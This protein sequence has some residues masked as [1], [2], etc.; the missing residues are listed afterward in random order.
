[1]IVLPAAVT[2]VSPVVFP[3]AS[4]PYSGDY[5]YI[6]EPGRYTLEHSV[7]HQYQAGVIIAAPSVVLDGQG[8][9][10]QPAVSG[11]VQSVGIWISLT[12]RLGRPVTGVTIRNV[13]IE[14]EGYGIYAE[15]AD[16]SEFVWGSDRTRDR[17]AV[18]AVSSPRSLTL[19][20]IRISSCTDGIVLRNQSGATISDVMVSGNTGS[21]IRFSGNQGI[22]SGSQVTGNSYD[23]VHIQ[24]GSDVEISGCTIDKNGKNGIRL[25]QAEGIRIF[26]N[27]LNNTHNID[28]GPE[29]R[30]IILATNRQG[31]E[32]IIGGRI[33]GGNYWADGDGSLPV[34]AGISDADGDGIGDSPYDPGINSS[35]PLPLF[36]PGSVSPVANRTLEP[37]LT[38]NPI[39]PSTPQVITPVPVLTPLSVISGIH[40][41]IIS[42][43]IP[44]E[45]GAGK[46]YPVSLSL[47]N[48][49]SADWIAQHQVGIK[50][51]EDA[52]LYGPEWMVVPISDPVQSG[53]T[54]RM[55]F[56]IKAPSKSGSYPLK[57][58]A[59]R[60]GSGIEV[61]YGRAYSKT[62]TVS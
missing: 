1:M 47:Y 26:N 28:A 10:I 34:Q 2:S 48:D 32:N 11:A 9:S 8:Y 53:Q 5:I 18:A 3:P 6:T 57:Y 20:E 27:I 59:A 19:S 7:S 16:S 35:D 22:I 37:V 54:I 17:A 14:G 30:G 46:S 29:C 55:D 12:D 21:G 4:A 15:G 24:N 36:K 51:L 62:V 49:G 40:A 31:G 13:S 25:D 23:G 38:Q 52:A 58:Q 61:L 56:S 42:D 45:M 41:V 33:L 44:S 43:T 39:S 60:E 50:A